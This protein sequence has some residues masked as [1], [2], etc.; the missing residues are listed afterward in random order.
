GIGTDSVVSVGT[1]DLWAECAAAGLSG[2]DA[3]RMLTIEGARALGLDRD[4]GSFEAG[5]QGDL[6]VLSAY[7]S[8]RPTVRLTALAGRIVH[9][10]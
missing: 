8:N 6:A 4:I 5:K 3:L 7:P 2:N 10:A 1:L 9:R